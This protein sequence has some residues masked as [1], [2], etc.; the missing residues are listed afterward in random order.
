MQT[1]RWRVGING[2]KHG[3]IQMMTLIP[4]ILTMNKQTVESS[5]EGFPS[6][7]F[8]A[9]RVVRA[10]LRRR[11]AEEEHRR[12]GSGADG[13]ADAVDWGESWHLWSDDDG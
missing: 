11:L 8:I 4:T 13:E 1:W 6:H 10:I 2:D 3:L 5:S 12:S 7:D 9:S